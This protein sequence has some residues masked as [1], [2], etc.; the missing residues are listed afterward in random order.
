MRQEARKRLKAVG[1]VANRVVAKSGRSPFPAMRPMLL[2]CWCLPSRRH[3]PSQSPS[4]VPDS[5]VAL[6]ARPPYMH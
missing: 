4:A 5:V 6:R 2:W 3:S 1:C